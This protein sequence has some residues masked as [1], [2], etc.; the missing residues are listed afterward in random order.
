LV[1]FSKS[2]ATKQKW[3]LFSDNSVEMRKRE[4]TH[5]HSICRARL[6]SKKQRIRR[7]SGSLT[8]ISQN[9]MACKKGNKTG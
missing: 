5:Q 7:T 9:V 4:I 6:S 1:T 3:V 8:N 2:Y